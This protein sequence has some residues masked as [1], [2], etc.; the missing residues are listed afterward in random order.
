MNLFVVILILL[1]IYAPWVFPLLFIL[2]FFFLL[3]SFSPVLFWILVAVLVLVCVFAVIASSKKWKNVCFVETFLEFLIFSVPLH[4]QNPPSLST[5]LKC[6]GRFFNIDMVKRHFTK[7]YSTPSELVQL[8]R[9]R[10]LEISNEQKA[11]TSDVIVCR[12]ICIRSW[13][14]PNMNAQ[15][16]IF[17]QTESGQINM[18]GEILIY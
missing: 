2:L 8:F 3:Y 11:E 5:M 16:W 7:S 10:G 4:Y 9:S 13:N 15:W 6:A 18:R 14:L 1:S 12:L 17:F